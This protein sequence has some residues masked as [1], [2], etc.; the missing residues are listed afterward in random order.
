MMLTRKSQ[1]QK[2][3]LGEVIAS[4]AFLQSFKQMD[5]RPSRSVSRLLPCSQQTIIWFVHTSPVPRLSPIM[6]LLPTMRAAIESGLQAVS[7][8]QA[9]GQHALAIAITGT[10]AST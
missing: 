6:L 10:T 1:E 8:A 9:A 3:L 2:N 4:R 7:L 5:K